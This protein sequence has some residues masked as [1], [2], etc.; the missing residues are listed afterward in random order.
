MHSSHAIADKVE[1]ASKVALSHDE[2]PGEEGLVHQGG[3]DLTQHGGRKLLQ[4]RSL[5]HQT[6]VEKQLHLLANERGHVLED[7]LHTGLPVH[8]PRE[9]LVC[10]NTLS[11][12]SRCIDAVQ[13]RGRQGHSLIVL[14]QPIVRHRVPEIQIGKH[15]CKIHLTQ[16]HADCVNSALQSRGRNDIAITDRCHGHRGE[17]CC[18]PIEVDTIRLAVGV[19]KVVG[20]RRIAEAA[21]EQCNEAEQ[22]SKV[23]H[24]DRELENELHAVHPEALVGRLVDAAGNHPTPKLCEVEEPEP[25]DDSRKL[26][27]LLEQV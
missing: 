14:R 8:V 17:I 12:H 25:L 5:G 27:W 23:V 16:N 13:G 7:L 10:D 15:L 1:L 24:E 21:L 4:E 9:V 19:Q 11:Q 3:D 2:V 20:P 18:I 6:V 26:T 22:A